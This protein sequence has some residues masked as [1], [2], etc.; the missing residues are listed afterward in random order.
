MCSLRKTRRIVAIL[1]LAILLLASAAL[2]GAAAA[3]WTVTKTADTNDGVCNSDCSL[4]EA[5]AAAASGDTIIFDSGLSGSTITLGS[6]V[7]LSKNVT[8]DGSTLAASITLDG[9][10]A[11]RVFYVNSGV[12]ATLNRL[13][14]THGNAGGGSQGGGLINYGVLTVTDCFFS[15]NTAY[16]GGGIFNESVGTMT[17]ANCIF[18]ANTTV[19]GGGGLRNNGGMTVTNSTF[20]GN[21]GGTGWAGAS[22]PP[23][24]EG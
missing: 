6:V 9:R 24:G 14:I 5:V 4:R 10:N 3:T 13:T 11:N 2:P 16:Y 19:A 12:T 17:V 15:A 20:S 23:G 8:I 18:S 22:L 7:T 21:S 1:A